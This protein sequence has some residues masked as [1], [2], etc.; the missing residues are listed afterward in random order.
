MTENVS[1]MVIQTRE[2]VIQLLD[3][4]EQ[5]NLITRNEI[6]IKL[7]NLFN[8]NTQNHYEMVGICTYR[9]KKF[10]QCFRSKS[11]LQTYFC[12]IQD[13]EYFGQDTSLRI[14]ASDKTIED[15][16]KRKYNVTNGLRIS[17]YGNYADDRWLIIKIG[18]YQR[19]IIKYTK[20]ELIKYLDKNSYWGNF[21]K[22]NQDVIKNIKLALAGEPFRIVDNI[23]H[24]I[25]INDDVFGNMYHRTS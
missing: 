2:K 21:I 17:Q 24:V 14:L 16:V 15:T 19:F 18:V 1:E 7:P 13:N 20:D 25:K 12:F 11:P 3:D 5:L 10:F 8:L 6:T 22:S 23:A 9:P 4:I